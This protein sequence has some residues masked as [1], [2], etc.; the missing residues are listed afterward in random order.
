MQKRWKLTAL[1]L[2]VLCLACGCTQSPSRQ[3][4]NAKLLAYFEGLGFT[5]EVSPLADA[6][7]EREV[8][9]YNATVWQRLLLNGEHELLLY[10]DE[11]NRADYHLSR[12]DREAWPH[13][14]RFGLRFLLVYPGEDEAVVAALEGIEND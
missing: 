7:P 9:I 13:A 4:R 1:M 11:S 2:A 10:F 14:A 12:L 5:C 3:E 6:Q 8:P